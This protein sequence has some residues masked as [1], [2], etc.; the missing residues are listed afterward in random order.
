MLLIPM[1]ISTLPLLLQQGAVPVFALFMLSGVPLSACLS[2]V[3][4]FAISKIQKVT[5]S[6]YLGKVMSIMMATAQC[7]API[8]QILYGIG[9]DTNRAY[10]PI[11]IAFIATISL[12]IL[13]KLLYQNEK[14]I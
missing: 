9:F 3:S 13:S 4:I 14:E 5:S 1:G 10:L 8:G 11:M 2:I 7:A 12:S 6:K